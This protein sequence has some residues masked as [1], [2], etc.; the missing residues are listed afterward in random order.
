MAL[1]NHS[2]AIMFSSELVW[3]IH[4]YMHTYACMYMYIQLLTFVNV[5][6]DL[7]QQLQVWHNPLREVVR[8]LGAADSDN[9]L[10][11]SGRGGTLGNQLWPYVYMCMCASVYMYV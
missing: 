6:F 2:P 1:V 7:E 10:T 4:V 11:Q 9:Q 5:D 3:C 8:I